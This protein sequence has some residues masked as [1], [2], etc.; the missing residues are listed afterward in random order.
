LLITAL[1][2]YEIERVTGQTFCEEEFQMAI[3]GYIPA[4]HTFKAFPI[5]LTTLDPDAIMSQLQDQPKARE[6]LNTRG[7]S[8]FF[9]VRTKLVVFPDN[10]FALWVSLAIRYYRID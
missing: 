10:I 6:I 3:K 2:N 8:V 9:G 7:E 5:Q 4:K 1:T